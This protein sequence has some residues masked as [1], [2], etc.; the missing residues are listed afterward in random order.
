MIRNLRAVP[1][2]MQVAEDGTLI[3][4]SFGAPT[5][6]PRREYWVSRAHGY[7]IV[8]QLDWGRPPPALPA[9]E[10]TTEFRQVDGGPFVAS[11]Q[12]V[13]SRRPRQGTYIDA[14]LSETKLDKTDLGKAPDDR[15]FTL[16]GLNLPVGAQISDRRTGRNY[17]YGMSAVTEEEI[18]QAITE[19][20]AQGTDGTSRGGQWV[21]LV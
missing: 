21:W 20:I 9:Q 8:R 7:G 10:L 3:K 5:D 6:Y 18:N 19:M 12:V 15:L 4:L 1:E 14:T 17:L 16:E 2:L 13:L 11:R